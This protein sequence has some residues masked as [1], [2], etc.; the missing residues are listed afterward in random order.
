MAVINILD[1]D[2][3]NKINDELSQ[4]MEQLI[5]DNSYKNKV[6]TKKVKEVNS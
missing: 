3:Y 1:K 4:K 2:V 6:K 5:K